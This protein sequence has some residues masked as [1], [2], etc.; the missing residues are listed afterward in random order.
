MPGRRLIVLLVVLLISLSI[1]SASRDVSRTRLPGG[2]RVT[3]SP[4]KTTPA[5]TSPGT[6][7]KP[8]ESP[9]P[10]VTAQLP[11]REAVRVPLGAR[12]QLRVKSGRPEVVT[13]D[14][15]GLRAP[16]G[17][18]TASTLDFVASQPGTFPVT[19]SVSGRRVGEVRVRS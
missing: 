2:P 15:L 12:V 1:L 6:E 14:E 19:L 11:S 3:T 7:P 4:P 10:T 5:Q 8:K 18:G 17:P 16:A 9:T 13:I